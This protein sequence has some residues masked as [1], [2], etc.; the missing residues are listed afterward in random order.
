MKHSPSQCHGMLERSWCNWYH[1][2]LVQQLRFW[3]VDGIRSRWFPL[4]HLWRSCRSCLT[5]NIRKSPGIQLFP[6]FFTLTVSFSVS[7]M[8]RPAVPVHVALL[9]G[10]IFTMTAL[11]PLLSPFFYHTQPRA[12]PTLILLESAMNTWGRDVLLFFLWFWCL[13]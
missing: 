2:A 10:C 3:S 4:C 12:S 7:A 6:V 5:H 13:P 9:V 1:R 11:K 8:A